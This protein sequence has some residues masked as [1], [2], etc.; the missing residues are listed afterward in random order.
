MEPSQ[1]TRGTH[2]YPH[3]RGA[4]VS[5]PYWMEKNVSVWCHSGFS[6][7]PLGSPPLH[8]PPCSW[9]RLEAEAGAP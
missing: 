2:G 4:Y 3:F 7:K 5:N 8:P 9:S 6:N 1:E